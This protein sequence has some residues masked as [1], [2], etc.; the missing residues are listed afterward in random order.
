MAKAF[1]FC[2]LCW[3]VVDGDGVAFGYEGADIPHL[4]AVNAEHHQ[5]GAAVKVV[6]L[7]YILVVIHQ[8]LVQV[9]EA[10]QGFDTGEL[11][12]GT[13]NGMKSAVKRPHRQGDNLIVGEIQ[14]L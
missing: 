5:N 9:F 4:R 1:L 2:L 12:V 8:H 3:V 10:C 6:Y 11:I 7:A 14:H 13:V